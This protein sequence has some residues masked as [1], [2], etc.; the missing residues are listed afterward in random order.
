MSG[1]LAG[2]ANTFGVVNR[3]LVS[4]QSIAAP[5]TGS[6][7]VNKPT[8][9]SRLAS[10]IDQVSIK[11]PQLETPK[12]LTAPMNNQ[13]SGFSMAPGKSFAPRATADYSSLGVE[14]KR[15]MVQSYPKATPELSDVVVPKLEP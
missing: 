3:T 13:M 2:N 8:S 6:F 14:L 7:K 15:Q 4:A 1:P 9:A 5:S 11:P 10:G 12:G